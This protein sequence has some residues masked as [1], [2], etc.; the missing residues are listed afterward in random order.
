ML[1]AAGILLLALGI[2]AGALLV[3]A[4]LGLVPASAGLALWILFPAFTIGGYLLAAAPA[5]DARIPMLSKLTGALLLLLA[6]G[7]GVALVLQGGALIEP[8][9]G[10]FSLWYVLAIGLVLGSMGLASH[11]DPPGKAQDA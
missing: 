6:L 1:F 4:P 2:F 7:A 5:K 10:T 11:R 9:G 3:L 8:R